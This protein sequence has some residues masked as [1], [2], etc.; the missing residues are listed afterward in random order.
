[1]NQ[2]INQTILLCTQNLTGSQLSLLH[3]PRNQNNEGKQKQKTDEHKI[4]G[5]KV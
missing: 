5:K 4:S 2:S 3:V 1:M